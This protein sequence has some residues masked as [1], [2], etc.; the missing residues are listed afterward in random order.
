MLLDHPASERSAAVSAPLLGEAELPRSDAEQYELLAKQSDW[1]WIILK[2]NRGGD[3][4][5][6][7]PHV[8][9]HGRTL[10][11]TRQ[12]RIAVS[13]GHGASSIFL[14]NRDASSRWLSRQPGIAFETPFQSAR[15][16]AASGLSTR[17]QA[18]MRC[19]RISSPAS[20]ASPRIIC[21][22]IRRCSC[23]TVI[24]MPGQVRT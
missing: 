23:Q 13:S 16:F 21:S 19:R 5:P 18:S 14:D 22:R 6:K 3:R 20:S 4:M 7:E 2:I 17:S 8:L 24:D 1:L 12:H 11:H 10:A 9:A 15:E